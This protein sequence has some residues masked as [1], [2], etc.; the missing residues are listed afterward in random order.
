MLILANVRH[1]LGHH[2]CTTVCGVMWF[3]W[4]CKIYHHVEDVKVKE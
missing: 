2:H 1:H 4:A 3:S